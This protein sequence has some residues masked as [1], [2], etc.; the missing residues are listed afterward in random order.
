MATLYG[1]HTH[2]QQ[3]FQKVT[4]DDW[5]RHKSLSSWKIREPPFLHGYVHT[6]RCVYS[7]VP[8]RVYLERNRPLFFGFRRSIFALAF[9]ASFKWSLNGKYRGHRQH[10]SAPLLPYENKGRRCARSRLQGEILQDKAG[11]L[12]T[13][14]HTCVTISTRSLSLS[15]F[16][17][18]VR[19]VVRSELWLPRG[20]SRV[21]GYLFTSFPTRRHLYTI[22][23]RWVVVRVQ[24][25]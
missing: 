8:V 1:T 24:R 22:R 10:V 19:K 15:R 11:S 2:T 14:T 25:Y 12:H 13:Q 17:F 16:I 21:F 7:T 18:P 4:R 3:S 5:I 20:E 23:R 6:Q 9:E